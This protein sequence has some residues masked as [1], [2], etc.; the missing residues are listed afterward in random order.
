MSRPGPGPG[1]LGTAHW[2]LLSPGRGP[3]CSTQAA[4]LCPRVPSPPR[5][6]I[7][8]SAV[9]W[10][11]WTAWTL[12]TGQTSRLRTRE[13]SG[14]CRSRHKR[15]ARSRP[16]FYYSAAPTQVHAATRHTALTHVPLTHLTLCRSAVEYHRRFCGGLAGGSKKSIYLR[17]TK[18][19]DITRQRQ[20]VF[21]VRYSTCYIKRNRKAATA[22]SQRRRHF[23]WRFRKC[24]CWSAG[25]SGGGAVTRQQGMT[26]KLSHILRWYWTLLF[27]SSLSF[28][29][30]T[31]MS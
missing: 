22:D 17:T 23:R 11:A 13:C 21:C 9:L 27:L 4:S 20:R 5:T 30:P 19:H 12:D 6:T 15:A 28:N 29:L 7:L 18:S 25:G 24:L 14:G 31:S 16:P 2:A 10:T 3:S 8:T 1:Q 26:S